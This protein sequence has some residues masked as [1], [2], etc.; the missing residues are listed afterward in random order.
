MWQNVQRTIF[1]KL[2]SDLVDK[3]MYDLP[4]Q[5]IQDEICQATNCIWH[6]AVHQLRNLQSARERSMRSVPKKMR[7]LATM[8]CCQRFAWAHLD[9]KGLFTIFCQA[10]VITAIND[11]SNKNSN[12]T[13]DVCTKN[14]SALPHPQS[15]FDGSQIWRSRWSCSQLSELSYSLNSSIKYHCI[16]LLK[17]GCGATKQ[18]SCYCIAPHHIQLQTSISSWPQEVQ[19]SRP[20]LRQC[21]CCCIQPRIFVQKNSWNSMFWLSIFWVSHAN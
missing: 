15:I 3:K 16:S 19:R 12:S 8:A 6:T 2:A 5:E 14:P 7:P 17:A 13:V 9:W 11:K 18:P 4:N 20:I 10:L 1:K 21:T